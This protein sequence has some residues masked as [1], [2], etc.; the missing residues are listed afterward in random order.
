MPRT[1]DVTRRRFLAG[2]AAT[3][4]LLASRGQAG[5]EE[6]TTAGAGAEVPRLTLATDLLRPQFHLLPPRG[7][8][9][10]PNGPIVWNGKVH[11][12]YQVNPTGGADWGE[13]SW[14]HA[15]S[16]DMVHWK[17]QPVALRPTPSFADSYG[18]FSGSCVKDGDRCLA[19]YTA[20]EQVDGPA[21]ATLHGD[22]EL[23]EQ[24]V[25][26]VS[27]DP[28]L[29]HWE[30]QKQ[31][32]I[33]TPPIQPTA[34]FRD[35]C[36]WRDG[37]T[38]YMVL[39]SGVIDKY[40]AVVLYK[41]T[42]P[43]GPGADWQYLHPLNQAPGNGKHTPDTV[44]AGTMWECPDFFEL[45]GH[46]VLLYSTERK[47]Y[48]M[49]GELDRTTLTF[50]PRQ[51]GMLDTGAYYAPKSMVGPKGE[52]ILWGWIPEKRD[53]AAY[54]A[55]GWSGAMALP[56]ILRVDAD[57]KLRQSVPTA[58][59]GLLI[60]SPQ[61][62][63]ATSPAKISGLAA[64]VQAK[65]TADG[66]AIMVTAEGKP[67]LALKAVGADGVEINGETLSAPLGDGVTAW[68]DGSVIE[69]FFGAHA[70]HTVRAYPPLQAA[71]GL[72]IT[73]GGAGLRALAQAVK[74]VSADRLTS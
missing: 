3:A 47:V 72:T 7:W 41:A 1:P 31:P 14:G 32:L 15:V 33:N 37:D 53:K 2:T 73:V 12:F 29:L 68:I 66:D 51:H 5:A 52:R 48:W 34:G 46:F 62:V 22:K 56:R 58:V 21:N 43:A 17:H 59:E 55:A 71:A 69:V 67:L 45:D 20:V 42:V 26:A 36:I 25:V 61:T 6:L 13:I 11:L 27:R 44:D 23:R 65:L 39:G 30:R 54:I 57:G 70:V 16:A 49:T 19:F 63:S 8:M 4:A 9:N 40:G 24:Q 18:V 38:W 64:R 60:G 50:Q 74:P 10:D 35:P 28:D